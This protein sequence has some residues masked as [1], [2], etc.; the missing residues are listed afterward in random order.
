MKTT[1][2]ILVSAI[3]RILQ[4]VKTVFIYDRLRLWSVL[5]KPLFHDTPLLEGFEDTK[6]V[7]RLTIACLNL[8]DIETEKD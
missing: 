3:F 8:I 1:R 2:A 4:V 6:E 5:V 7:I